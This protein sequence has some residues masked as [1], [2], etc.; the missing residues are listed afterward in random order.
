MRLPC[1]KTCEETVAHVSLCRNVLVL[2]TYVFRSY[3][4][5][6]YLLCM[7]TLGDYAIPAALTC[8]LLYYCVIFPTRSSSLA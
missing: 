8:S 5:I 1:E 2:A 3:I 4:P 6:D 7:H